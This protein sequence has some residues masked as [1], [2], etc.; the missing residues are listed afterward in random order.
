MVNF[1]KLDNYQE[2]ISPIEPWEII[3]RN[4][5]PKYFN[6][7]FSNQKDILVDW[8]KKRNQK[9]TVIKLHTGGGKT[10]VG[11]LIAQSTMDELG[12]PV[13]Y[14]SPT[15]QLA[16][17]TIKMAEDFGIKAVLYQKG[18][19]LSNEFKNGKSIMVASYKALFNGKS[20]FGIVG[21]GTKIP[22]KIG[23]IILDDAHTSFPILRDSF[24]LTINK[25]SQAYGELID[26]FRE[27]FRTI[28]KMG[29]LDDIV[30]NKENNIIEVPYWSWLSKTDAVVEILNRNKINE[31]IEWPL[32]RNHLNL[33][34]TLINKNE[35]NIT[36]IL[37][38][39]DQFS[40]FTECQRRIYMSA[41]IADDSNLIKMFDADFDSVQNPLSSSS[42]AGISERM[43]LTPDLMP[44]S[45]D[46]KMNK[47]LIEHFVKSEGANT[48][49]LTNSFTESEKYEDIGYVAKYNIEKYIENLKNQRVEKPVIFSN[50]YDGID[51]PNDACR[52]LVMNG[53]PKGN[54]L[55]EIYLSSIL[56][57]DSTI[58]NIIAQRIEQGI[59]RAARGS[60]D[61]CVVLLVGKELSDWISQNSNFNMLTSAT[62]SQLKIGE[63]V[64]E[65]VKEPEELKNTIIQSLERDE[66]WID[67]HNSNLSKLLEESTFEKN[68][69]L[70]K[71]ERKSLDL[72]KFGYHNKAIDKLEKYVAN[73]TLEDRLSGWYEHNIAR[74]A[75]DWGNEEKSEDSYK[76]A[77]YHNNNLNRPKTKAPYRKINIP[78]KQ[79]KQIAEIIGAY[80]QRQ[81]I[82]H[83]F[84]EI[85]KKL[86]PDSSSNQ[87]EESL[88]ELGRFLGF[89]SQR[90]DYNGSGPDILW[91]ISEEKAIVIEAKSRKKEKNS[92]NKENHGQLLVAGEWFRQEYPN[93]EFIRA[94]VHPN[95]NAT[96]NAQAEESYVLT[97]AK[98]NLLKDDI[99]C[100]LKNLINSHL[101]KSSLEIECENL[102]I[103]TDLTYDKIIDKY[104]ERFKTS[105]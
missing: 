51:L 40:S 50:R 59:G 19:P 11:L 85:S 15:N 53:L 43:I 18:Q 30:S 75:F 24:T 76:Q 48:V 5:K 38:L 73:H 101:D 34:H 47:M 3:N 102:L 82:L 4:R 23:G 60:G 6:D 32:L 84:D 61:Y 17:Q 31:N 10:L 63:K 55:Y 33:C 79:S 81:A 71:V 2:S 65:A 21:S 9:D 66:D 49:V 93:Y 14:L 70:A 8:F 13:L 78:G 45:Y 56:G 26:L 67:H 44:F 86:H 36:P 104:F 37:P 54:S 35:I 87:F 80:R 57:N 1:K 74:I 27:D 98:L 16:Q 94:S 72:W 88:A 12:E 83:K 105:S 92:F 90:L 58:A 20:K 69:T 91:L 64:S 29:T 52:L 68:F 89:S 46:E 95:N 62:K 42:L 7:L 99:R 22:Q 97:Y 41:T 25:A 103:N 96:S 100:F 77:F 28:D 39:I